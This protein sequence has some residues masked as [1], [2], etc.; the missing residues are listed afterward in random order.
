M[1]KILGPTYLDTMKVGQKKIESRNFWSIRFVVQKIKNLYPKIFWLQKV[2]VKK[3][4]TLKDLG[5]K[6]IS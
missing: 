5:Q 6:E 1:V 2:L 3:D 4:L